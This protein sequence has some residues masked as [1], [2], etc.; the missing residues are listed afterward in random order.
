MKNVLI[1][2]LKRSGASLITVFII[3]LII[4]I[5]VEAL[6]GDVAE[7]VLGQGATPETVE[8]FRK[9]LKLDLPPHIRY[10]AWLNDFIHGEFGNS[11][12]NGRPVAGLIG[13][14]FGN[15]LFLALSTAMIA[16]PLAIIL[17]MLAALYRNT[18]FDKLISTTTLSFISFPEFFIAY[19]LISILSVKMNI[20]PSLAVI[21]PEMGLSGRIYAII[22]PSL[23][24]T[25]VVTAHMMRQTRAA[26]I[27][28]LASAYIEMA[29]IK[30]MKRLRIIVLHAFPNSLSPVIN[31]IAVNMAYLIVGVVLVEVVF[32]YPGLG[33][34]LVDSVAKRD[35][36]VVQASGLVFSIVYISLNLLADILSMLSNP[37]LRQSQI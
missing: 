14:R 4:F 26:I 35:L 31:V 23:T 22:L 15:T 36:P 9:E 25:C 33:Q 13:W 12:A 8:A 27:N 3:S 5:G 16:I 24:L 18:F 37:K 2:I 7:T 20:F 29:E 10:G 19:I 17:G 6:P 21:D 1:L 34:L 28:V 32:V 11:L 30:G